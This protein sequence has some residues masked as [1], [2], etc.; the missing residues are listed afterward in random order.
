MIVNIGQL[1]QEI[2]ILQGARVSPDL[3]SL[4]EVN[5]NVPTFRTGAYF[6]DIPDTVVLKI[7]FVLFFHV[8][9]DWHHGTIITIHIT[10]PPAMLS[11]VYF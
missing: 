9:P 10:T 1:V 5:G 4:L 8:H 7:V 6:E 11:P 2:H 3:Q